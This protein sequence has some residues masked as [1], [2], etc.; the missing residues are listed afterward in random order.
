MP[1]KTLTAAEKRQIAKYADK[2][3]KFYSGKKMTADDR[4]AFLSLVEG[5]KSR[6]DVRF[7]K[8]AIALWAA[9]IDYAIVYGDKR[10][11]ARLVRAP[12][13]PEAIARVRESQFWDS[14]DGCSCAMSR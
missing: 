12:F 8:E 7:G 6:R 10:K 2:A 5:L 14:N 9:K 1:T 13:G 11:A 3:V 4:A